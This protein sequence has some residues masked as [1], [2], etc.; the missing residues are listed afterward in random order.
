MAQLGLLPCATRQGDVILVVEAEE[1]EVQEHA[2]LYNEFRTDLGYMG[3]C[4]QK[5]NKTK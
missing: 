2:R 3:P 5:Q 4:L 1:S